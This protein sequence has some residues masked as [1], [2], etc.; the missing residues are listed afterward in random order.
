MDV[1]LLVLWPV[2]LWASSSS[3]LMGS[4]C[5][6]RCRLDNVDIDAELGSVIVTKITDEFSWEISYMIR[7]WT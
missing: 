5:V 2:L 1:C 6:C 7:P 3:S 4:V